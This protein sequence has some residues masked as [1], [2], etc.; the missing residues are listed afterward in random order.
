MA[1]GRGQQGQQLAGIADQPPLVAGLPGRAER[2]VEAIA[3]LR[4]AI[5]LMPYQAEAHLLLGRL[6]QR[7]GRVREAID[8]LKIAIWID[9][10]NAA[11]RSLLETLSR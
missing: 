2:D 8:S 7:T 11:A 5:Y 6:Y 1:G 3:E 9:P 10:E 4:R